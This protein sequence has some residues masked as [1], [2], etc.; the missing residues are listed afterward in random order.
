MGIN[1]YLHVLVYIVWLTL[2]VSDT[3]GVILAAFTIVLHTWNL[4]IFLYSLKYTPEMFLNIATFGAY[5][6]RGV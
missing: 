5:S 1:W 6:A 2:F 3:L 4:V